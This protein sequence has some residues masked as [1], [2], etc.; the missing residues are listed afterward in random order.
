MQMLYDKG[1]V[2]NLPNIDQNMESYQ[3]FK[4]EHIL[5]S[6]EKPNNMWERLPLFR[7]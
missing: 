7:F 4:H 5:K 1:L 2:E 3:N 6:M